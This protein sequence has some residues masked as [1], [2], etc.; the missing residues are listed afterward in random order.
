M[1]KWPKPLF[2]VLCPKQ[3]FL[4]KCRQ[5]YFSFTDVLLYY[6]MCTSHEDTC[7]TSMLLLLIYEGTYASVKQS[8]DINS[9]VRGESH[10]DR[11]DDRFRPTQTS[12]RL[13]QTMVQR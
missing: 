6:K 12:L 9:S 11:A 8:K 3:T 5:C 2:K 7:F 10:C 1:Y 13:S 4:Y